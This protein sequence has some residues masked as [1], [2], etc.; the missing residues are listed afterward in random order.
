VRETVERHQRLADQHRFVCEAAIE[1]LPG[2][3]DG[4]RLARV[5]DNVFGNAIKYSPSGGLIRVAIDVGPPPPI[6]P[7]CA[8]IEAPPESSSCS[9]VVL[10]VEDQGIGIDAEDLPHVFEHFQR[11]ANVPETVVGSGIGLTSVAQVV[12]QHGG[13]IAIASQLGS[14]TRVTIWLP[15]HHVD[16][17]EAGR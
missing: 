14:G 5:L 4:P 1:S 3:W 13:Q 12:R 9:G 11:G 6:G 8:A 15:R 2:W 7:H 16:P 17:T 10:S